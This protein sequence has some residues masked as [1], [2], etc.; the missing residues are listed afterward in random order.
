MPISTIQAQKLSI[1]KYALIGLGLVVAFGVL[2]FL[3]TSIINA[4]Q[5]A[6]LSASSLYGASEI[7]LNDKYVGNTPYESKDIRAGD[8]KIIFKTGD[9]MYQTTLPFMSGAQVVVKRDL[10]TSDLFSAG[11]NF[12]MEKNTSGSVLSVVSEPSGASVFVDNTEIGKTPFSSST[13]SDGEYDLRVDIGQYEPQLSR[14]KI[15][16]GYNLNVAAK[17]FPVP[18]PGSVVVFE[19]SSNLYNLSSDNLILTADPQSW[20]DAVTYWNK[21]RGINL[22]GVGSNKELVFDFFIDYK[23]GLYDK[24]GS[25]ASDPT[26]LTDVK[27]GAYLGKLSDD[28][29]LSTEAAQTYKT[30]TTAPAASVVGKTAKIKTTPTGWLRVRDAANLNGLELAKVNTGETYAILEQGTD[31]LKIK[32][33]DTISGWVSAAYVDIVSNQ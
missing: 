17:L 30:L 28:A 11:Q 4:K 12:W 10:G 9:R 1:K 27:K 15:Q 25:L 18:V 23:G 14:I 19:G 26:K 2:Y 20:V 6:A 32:V 29:V 31:W 16:K 5:I 24:N 8:T 3:V 33:S 22:A 21:T 7:S 13:L